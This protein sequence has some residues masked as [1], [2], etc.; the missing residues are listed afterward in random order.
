MV[1]VLMF[2]K[3]EPSLARKVKLVVPYQPGVG[4]K[5]KFPRLAVGMMSFSATGVPFRR[6]VPVAGAGSVTTWM[7]AIG[8]PSG[9]L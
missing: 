5:V 4:T 7:L 3:I 2:E 6:S 1:S 8:W 9:S